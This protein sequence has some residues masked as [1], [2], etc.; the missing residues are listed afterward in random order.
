[1][2][3]RTCLASLSLARAASGI[4]GA[5]LAFLAITSPP[6]ARTA[7]RN[8]AAVAAKFDAWSAGAGNPFELLTDEASW[9]IEGNS[10]AS[11]DLRDQG[12]LSP[13]RHSSV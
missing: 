12:G 10:V 6:E 7:S 8:K 1:M 4:A 2:N 3:N 11:K 9:T 5:G 13:R